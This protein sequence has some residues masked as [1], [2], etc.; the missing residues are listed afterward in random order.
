MIVDEAALR[1]LVAE[2]VRAVIREEL[3]R[4]PSTAE[5]LAVQAAADRID[6]APAT[7]REWI[8]IG[9]L[10]RYHAGRELRVKVA[11]LEALV[12]WQP[13]TS[14]VATTSEPTPEEL[15]ERDARQRVKT[16]TSRRGE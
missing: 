13:V 12:A 15:A 14:R 2:T 10:G 3:D 5:Y 8:N 11:E 4:A 6:V 9:R 1:T 7:I 16:R